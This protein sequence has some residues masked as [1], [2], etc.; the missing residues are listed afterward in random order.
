[1]VAGGEEGRRGQKR[2]A[3][4]RLQESGIAASERVLRV[5]RPFAQPWRDPQTLTRS[6]GRTRGSRLQGGRGRGP[7]PEPSTHPQTR[8]PPT[9][10]HPPGVMS[11][12]LGTAPQ[13]G[14]EKPQPSSLVGSEQ[15]CG[16][17]R[18]GQGPS[19][20]QCSP[21]ATAQSHVVTA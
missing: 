6:G 11:C 21:M 13:C 9:W 12:L 4:T 16:R 5:P 14:A 19:C 20:D 15:D 8:S 18:P 1:M 7:G 10:G 3:H 17:E 2:R